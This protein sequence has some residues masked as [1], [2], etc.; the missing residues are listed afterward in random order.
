MAEAPR[1]RTPIGLVCLGLLALIAWLG[2]F[3]LRELGHAYGNAPPSPDSV[4][5]VVIVVAVMSLGFAGLALFHRGPFSR[6][7]ALAP[8]VLVL[9]GEVLVQVLFSGAR[10]TRTARRA[11]HAA[12]VAAHVAT[13]PQTYVAATDEHGHASFLFVDENTGF[14]M[15]IGHDADSFDVSCLGSIAEGT[16]T[17]E[18]DLRPGPD[19]ELLDRIRRRG[20]AQPAERLRGRLRRAAEPLALR[21]RAIRAQVGGSPPT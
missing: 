17:V 15:L 20:W 21:L 4:S 10:S 1:R 6:T 2:W 14:L 9:L 8:V 18:E 3:Y 19:E 5:L 11:A 16:L 7:Y 12:E 13:L